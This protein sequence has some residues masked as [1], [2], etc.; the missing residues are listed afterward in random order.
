MEKYMSLSPDILKD[1]FLTDLPGIVMVFNEKRICIF[2][3]SEALGFFGDKIVGESFDTLIPESYPH[4]MREAR[5]DPMEETLIDKNGNKRTFQYF[6][7]LYDAKGGQHTFVQAFEITAYKNIEREFETQGRYFRGVL[8]HDASLIYTLNDRG[9]VCLANAA[10][11]RAL[12]LPLEGVIG[13]KFKDI[14]SDLSPPLKDTIQVY[15]TLREVY[16]QHLPDPKTGKPRRYLT[17]ALP[18]KA[19]AEGEYETLYVMSDITELHAQREA[20]KS[21]RDQA[22][23]ANMTKSEFLANMSHELRTPL[24]I[25]INFADIMQKQL[26]GELPN[27]KYRDYVKA[28]YD[29]GVHLLEVINDILDLSKIEA[30]EMEVHMAGFSLTPVIESLVRLLHPK[31]E[32]FSLELKLDLPDPNIRV[33]ADELK[34]KQVLL[35]LLSNAMKFTPGGGC[36]TITTCA[37]PPNTVT[38]MV[39]DTGIGIKPE[40][41]SRALQRFGQ[42]Q[43]HLKSRSLS[44]SGLGLALAKSYTEMMGGTFTLESSLGK[45][46]TATVRLKRG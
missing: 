18:I 6:Y 33:Y 46:T 9:V 7:R 29:S 37:Q 32:E 20:L 19:L 1:A 27:P 44:G 11:A 24:N 28:I 5:G 43:N 23:S 45:G 39:S 12:N 34:L 17:S 30:G 41:I 25:V 3:N 31:M 26:M 40:E 15:S 42:L 16:E 22:E 10:F 21:A 36:I 2:A 38:L 35:N 8:D 14:S 4:L 13:S